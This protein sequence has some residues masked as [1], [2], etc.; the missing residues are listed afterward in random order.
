M[1]RFENRVRIEVK[2]EHSSGKRRSGGK[3]K[4]SGRGSRRREMVGEGVRG[5]R[6]E[7]G[8]VE[9]QREKDG[10]VENVEDG[11]GEEEDKGGIIGNGRWRRVVEDEGRRRERGNRKKEG[12]GVVVAGWERKEEGRRGRGRGKGKRRL[13][14]VYVDF[15]LAHMGIR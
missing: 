6:D 9:E 14:R 13:I 15:K 10:V 4:G 5:V 1:S 3:R 11:G 7:G 2:C 12:I 8:V